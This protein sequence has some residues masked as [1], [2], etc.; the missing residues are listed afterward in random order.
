MINIGRLRT[1]PVYD[2][3]PLHL[4]KM[5]C[6]ANKICTI[7]QEARTEYALTDVSL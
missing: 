7:C 1:C 4:S 2:L 3:T 6:F 5:L